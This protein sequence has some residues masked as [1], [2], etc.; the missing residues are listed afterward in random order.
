MK[1]LESKLVLLLLIGF[2]VASA[3]FF[4]LPFLPWNFHGPAGLVAAVLTV[5]HIVMNRNT[6]FFHIKGMKSKKIHPKA[7][8]IFYV[9]AILLFVWIVAA[10]SGII[11]L[12]QRLFLRQVFG[13]EGPYPDSILVPIHLWFVLATIVMIILHFILHIPHIKAGLQKKNNKENK[14]G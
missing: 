2:F 8:R 10:L 1:T 6:V 11:R 14:A 4:Y 13:L 9:N 12:L 3:A 5:L 7:K